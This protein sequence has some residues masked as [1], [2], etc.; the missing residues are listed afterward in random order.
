MKC[1]FC[2]RELRCKSCSRLFRARSSAAHLGVFQPDMEIFC[3]ECQAV[4]VCK[5]CGYVYGDPGQ[6]DEER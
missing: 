2:E 1:S 3:P 6:E 4:L 5:E